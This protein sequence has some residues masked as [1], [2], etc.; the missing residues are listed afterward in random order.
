MATAPAFASTPN[1]GVGRPATAETD[2]Q[3]PAQSVVVLTAGASGTKIEE[4]VVAAAKT[5]SL[6]VTTVAGLVLLFLYDGSVYHP[7]DV[8]AV[9]AVSG[10]ATAAPFR[11]SN[12]YAN[13]WL[14]S[15]WSLRASQ[16]I[17]GNASMLEV[18]AF[19]ADL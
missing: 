16:T 12:R 13:L 4:I 1:I 10:T 7:F 11:A 9:T 8:I 6:T 17:A 15:G 2:S 18:T 19:G 5:A 14:K 3:T